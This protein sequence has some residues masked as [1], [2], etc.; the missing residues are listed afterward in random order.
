M[1]HNSTISTLIYQKYHSSSN[2]KGKKM[3]CEPPIKPPTILRA[4]T[5]KVTA[6][7]VDTKKR[8]T[9]S[10][11][12]ILEHTK[13]YDN[14]ILIVMVVYRLNNYHRTWHLEG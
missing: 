8:K 13:R 2:F 5:Y 14:H 3:K 1:I 4:I 10:Y 11:K 7:F 9:T 6:L 12:A